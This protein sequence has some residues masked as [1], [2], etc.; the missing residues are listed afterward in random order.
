MASQFPRTYD[1]KRIEESASKLWKDKGVVE[2]AISYD[3]KKPLF[4]FLEGPPTANAPPAL[5]HVEMRTIKDL[6]CRYKFMN[7]FSVPRKAGWDCHGLPVE[8]Q[9]EKKLGLKTKKDVVNYG[10]DKFN[11]LCR[12]D[13]FSFISEW[14]KLTDKMAF[15]IDLKN[16]YV[17]LNNDYIE[18]VW[19]SVQQL[20][21]KGLLY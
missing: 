3:E 4:S 19:W 10:I 20:Y 13:V 9:V 11:A 16:P 15:W 14:D 8:V 21:K 2:K 6:V 1:V 5:H 18:S 7:G 17:T 12:S